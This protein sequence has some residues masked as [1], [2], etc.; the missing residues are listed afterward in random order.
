MSA[1]YEL[2]TEE[3]KE[4][5]KEFDNIQNLPEIP[6][7]KNQYPKI[8][9]ILLVLAGILSLIFWLQNYLIDV[10]YL[11]ESGILS[12]VQELDLDITA[13]ELVSVLKTCA[14]I[15]IIV[16]I[17]PL[18]GGI[19]SIKRKLFGIVIVCSIIGIFSLGILFLS[20]IFSLIGL[21]LLFVS[22][23]EY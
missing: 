8:A 19:L 15:G 17:F 7:K 3:D 18:L 10:I 13:E 2:K 6:S 4:E 23:K 11:E 14:T 20:S 5:Q 21:I 9:G 12:Q 16:S 22:R 1:N